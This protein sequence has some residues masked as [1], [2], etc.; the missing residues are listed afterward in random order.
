MNKKQKTML[1]RIIA[2]LII[3]IPLYVI[4]KKFEINI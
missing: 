2:A 3:Y 1:A 4:S